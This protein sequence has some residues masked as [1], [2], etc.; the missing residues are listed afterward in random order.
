VDALGGAF[1][2]VPAERVEQAACS[3]RGRDAQ[4][5]TELAVEVTTAEGRVVVVGQPEAGGGDPVAKHAQDARLAHARFADDH[6]RGMLVER[7][8][9]G[10]DD[11]ELG[12]RQ[13]QITVGD[14]LGERR[15]A[16]P[17]V[18]EVGLVHLSPPGGD[19]G[20]GD[21]RGGRARCRVGRKGTVGV[22]GTGCVRLR[23]VLP[24]ATASTGRST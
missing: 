3:R 21:R 5:V 7:F 9:Q 15:F 13:P 23:R 19:A 20:V 1:F 16:E 22:A 17:E 14:L 10:L 11:R 8:D 24:A 12:R 2:G 6:G 18:R 4:G